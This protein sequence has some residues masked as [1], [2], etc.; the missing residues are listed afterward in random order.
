MNTYETNINIIIKSVATVG[1]TLL[2]LLFNALFVL[3]VYSA[4]RVLIPTL[5]ALSYW[6]CFGLAWLLE[7]VTTKRVITSKAKET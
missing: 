5:P 4:F 3:L 7:K 2:A 6:H 1:G